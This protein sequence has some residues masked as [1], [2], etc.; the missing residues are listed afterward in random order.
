MKYIS[1][2]FATLL[3]LL[4]SCERGPVEIPLIELGTKET[5]VVLNPEGD[6]Y[7]MKIYANG[8]FSARITEGGDWLSFP[9]GQTFTGEGDCEVVLSFDD[10]KSLARE[11]SVVL[12]REH[13]KATVNFTQEGMFDVTL[14]FKG[15]NVLCD[16][17]GGENSAKL[18]SI[19]PLEKLNVK[20]DYS[21]GASDWIYDIRKTNNFLTFMTTDNPEDFRHATITVS[22]KDDPSLYDVLKVS[23]KGAESLT[24]VSHAQL[25]DLLTKEGSLTIEESLVLEGVVI[26]DN[27]QGNGAANSN[28]SGAIQDMTLADRTLY[29]QS[30]DATSGIC[31]ILDD[32]EANNTRRYDKVQIYL[33]GAVLTR[34]DAPV[35]YM[36]TSV[37]AENLIASTSGSAYDAQPKVTEIGQLT[38]E[39]IYTLVT[40]KDC[41]IPFRKGP[42]VPVDLRHRDVINRYPMPIRDKNGSSIHLMTNI[43]AAWERDGK[44]MPQGSGNIT[45]VLVYET[46][47]NFAWDNTVAA[48]KLGQGVNIGYITDIG[49]ISDYQIRPVTRE[50][51]ALKENFKDGFSEMIMEIRYTN[52]QYSNIILNTQ[53]N[54][55]HPTYPASSNPL[56]DPD[57]KST[58]RVVGPATGI[59]EFRDWTHLGPLEDGVITDKTTGN[60][61]YDANGTSCHWLIENNQFSLAS[62]G[63]IYQDNGS[64]W[65]ASGWGTNKYWLAKFPT[66]GITSDNFPLSVQFGAINGQGEGVGANGIGAPRYWKVEYSTNLG[67]SWITAHEYT[68]PDFSVLYKKRVWQCPGYKMITCNLPFDNELLGKEEIRVRL[69]PASTKAGTMDS[70]DGGTVRPDGKSALNYFAI[71]YNK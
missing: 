11:A 62:T 67:E 13:K 26:N 60:G 38:D 27:L 63:L 43:G 16:N 70:Y 61:V 21:E 40:L 65:Y 50:D 37:G 5:E 1:C 47:D 51:I 45:G 39:D 24:T 58:F 3:L 49:H 6:I 15:N 17:I 14:E 36:V 28:I 64:G 18:L 68:V 25:K 71:R 35:R 69:I 19:L 9:E 44:G 55:I 66:T 22:S 30:T 23:Q 52:K 56:E 7:L 12:E 29:I 34:K 54:I 42:F 53:G 48:E 8:P 4:S 41:E 10:N 59:A 57:L 46:C 2:I 20:I 33:K 32:K 31:V